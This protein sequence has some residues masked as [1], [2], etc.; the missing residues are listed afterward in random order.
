MA[1][2]LVKAP[3]P[4]SDAELLEGLCVRDERAITLTYRRY[5]RYVAGIAFRLL[6]SEDEVE[7]VVQHVFLELV[8]TAERIYGPESLK[9]FLLALTSRQVSRRLT[10]RWRARRLQSALELV[11]PRR[12]DPRE[13][14]ELDELYASLTAL[15]PELRM[16]WM[17]HHI[18]GQSLPETA[19]A[20]EVSLATVK[21]RI[22]RAEQLL[23]KRLWK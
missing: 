23:G 11:L 4:A 2:K 12:S 14:A 20:C 9:S 22:A 16:P 19:Q 8:R 10:R 7:D 18:E 6:G 5:S 15:S 3:A 21:R 13:A 1:L 17:L